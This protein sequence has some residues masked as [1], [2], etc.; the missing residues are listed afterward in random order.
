VCFLDEGKQNLG[1]HGFGLDCPQAKTLF[2][3]KGPGIRPG[4]LP[5]MDLVQIAPTLA[6]V[7]GLSL[8]DAQGQVLEI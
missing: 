6:K 1:E 2:L 8:P 4:T 3:L 7:L 5:E